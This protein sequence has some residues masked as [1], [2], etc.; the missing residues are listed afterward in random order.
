MQSTTSIAHLVR[1]IVFISSVGSY[2]TIIHEIPQVLVGILLDCI[3]DLLREDHFPKTMIYV[4]LVLPMQGHMAI[5]IESCICVP[6][7]W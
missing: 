3:T 2:D 4:G 1:D 5:C 7:G 6:P